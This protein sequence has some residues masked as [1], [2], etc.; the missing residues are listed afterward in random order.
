MN[1]IDS[2]QATAAIRWL[3]AEEGGRRTGPPTAPVYAATCIFKMGNDNEIHPNWPANAAQLSILIEKT[4]TL[5]DG[6]NAA[7]IGFLA[8]ELASPF[9]SKGQEILIMEGPKVVAH[10]TIEEVLKNS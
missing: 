8:P 5:P 6:R 4:N 9:L 10:A 2:P 7:M 1:E 3:T